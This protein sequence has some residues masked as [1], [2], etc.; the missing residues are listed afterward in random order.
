MGRHRSVKVPSNT[1]SVHTPWGCIRSGSPPAFATSASREPAGAIATEHLGE[2]HWRYLVGAD[3]SKGWVNDR[4]V[5]FKDNRVQVETEWE[6]EQ[7]ADAF[8]RAYESV[9][10]KRGLEPKIARNGAKVTATYT[11][12]S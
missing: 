6:S 3:A 7:R 11:A 5:I 10:Q 4:V 1:V 9:L 12:K 2:F 8:A